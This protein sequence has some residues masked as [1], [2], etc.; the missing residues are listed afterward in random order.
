MKIN[1]LV[2][3]SNLEWSRIRLFKKDY[4]SNLSYEVGK[5]LLVFAEMANKLKV[6]NFR[7][8]RNFFTS[9]LFAMGDYDLDCEI[10]DITTE[11]NKIDSDV[12]ILFLVDIKRDEDITVKF[13]DLPKAGDDAWANA[14]CNL[15]NGSGLEL[16]MKTIIQ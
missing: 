1:V 3:E 13:I 16:V 9:E 7:N 15:M 5:E 2:R 14:I 10:S 6:K 8:V 12:S 11:V 4:D